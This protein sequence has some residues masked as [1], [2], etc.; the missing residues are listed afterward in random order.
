M[1]HHDQYTFFIIPCSVLRRM[2][3]VSDRSCREDLNIYVKWYFAENHTVYEMMWRNIVELGRPQVTMWR[4]RIS[5]WVHK[6]THTHT[7]KVCNT[8]CCSAAAVVTWTRLNVTLY[9]HHLVIFLLQYTLVLL[10]CFRE[11]LHAFFCLT[12]AVL[13]PGKNLLQ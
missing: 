7:H 3:K 13:L 8:Y 11:E 4:M 2:W 9:V 5:R 6:A 12:W 10:Y 1:F